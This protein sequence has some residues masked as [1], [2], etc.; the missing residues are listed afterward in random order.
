MD[1][2]FNK[3]SLIKDSIGIFKDILMQP[4]D[5]RQGKDG[6]GTKKKTQEVFDYGIRTHIQSCQ[7]TR[8]IHEQLTASKGGPRI[9]I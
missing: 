4:I 6:L 7:D 3:N 5:Y 8:Q 9:D 1:K 2:N